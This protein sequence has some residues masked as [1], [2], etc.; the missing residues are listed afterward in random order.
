MSLRE[1]REDIGECRDCGELTD[2]SALCEPC[3]QYRYKEKVARERAAIL[4]AKAAV[5]D[6][7]TGKRGAA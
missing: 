6:L 5:L 2:G 1:D 4:A 3:Y 7:A